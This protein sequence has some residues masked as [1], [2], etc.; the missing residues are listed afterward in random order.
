MGRGAGWLPAAIEG[1]GVSGGAIGATI[2]DDEANV[3][4]AKPA[5]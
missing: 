1:R 5:E 3:I 2:V 4:D